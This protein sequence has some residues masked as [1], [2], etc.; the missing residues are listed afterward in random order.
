MKKAF[1]GLLLFTS[2]ATFAQEDMQEEKVKHSEVKINAFNLIVFK[3]VD[4]SYE[5]LI[6]SESSVGLS[7]LINLQDREDRDFISRE[8]KPFFPR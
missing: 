4:F 1:L 3:S 5:Y 7:V 8:I 2:F 6:D